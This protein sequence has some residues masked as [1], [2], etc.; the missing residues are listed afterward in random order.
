[1]SFFLL[2]SGILGLAHAGDP[3]LPLLRAVES[4]SSEGVRAQIDKV[5]EDRLVTSLTGLPAAAQRLD[6]NWSAYEQASRSWWPTRR[7]TQGMLKLISGEL[8]EEAVTDW[9]TISPPHYLGP[10]P[11]ERELKVSAVGRHFKV[12]GATLLEVAG[13]YGRG[14][15]V[16]DLGEWVRLNL[17]IKPNA[18]PMFSTSV[19]VNNSEPC[20]YIWG[21]NKEIVLDDAGEWRQGD[22]TGRTV[23]VDLYVSHDC[24]Q[25]QSIPVSIKIDDSHRDGDGELITTWFQVGTKPNIDAMVQL[26]RD[27]PGYSWDTT[28]P[29]K[30][31]S[32]YELSVQANVTGRQKASLLYRLVSDTSL[33]SETRD[34]AP[35]IVSMYS[36]GPMRPEDDLDFSMASRTAVN[37]WI[38]SQNR[39]WT[40]R[41]DPYVPFAVDVIAFDETVTKPPEATDLSRVVQRY[42]DLLSKNFDVENPLELAKL[43]SKVRDFELLV[44]DAQKTPDWESSKEI[45]AL[46]DE[47][48][49]SQVYASSIQRAYSY[50][51]VFML[52]VAPPPT[53]K[54]PP[55]PPPP[56][57][58][59]PPP[60]VQKEKPKPIFNAGPSLYSEQILGSR[61]LLFGAHT[62][63]G[64]RVKFTAD[65]AARQLGDDEKYLVLLTGARVNIV[66]KD[67]FEFGPIMSVGTTRATIEP[68]PEIP[69]SITGE[70]SSFSDGW[71]DTEEEEEE[72]QNGITFGAGVGFD[73]H[74]TQNFGAWLQV[75]G[76]A[77]PNLDET[78]GFS[79]AM[80]LQLRL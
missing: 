43:S 7:M 39:P 45:Q 24:S 20:V 30:P 40:E 41:P 73:F 71:D 55:P 72:T 51:K 29:L 60:V 48:I 27:I 13:T 74:F 26:D 18:T 53:V 5:A 6:S 25:G 42:R 44:R 50:R 64:K 23:A 32:R 35:S 31:E 11:A 22:K 65:V 16:L 80:G 61:I 2:T 67:R 63:V 75:G 47:L 8:A 57:A 77:S 3:A 36:K 14:N 54:P 66:Y 52:P 15:G 9:L 21:A 34:A 38:R 33:F 78:G 56:P 19:W 59:V 17:N 37:T 10:D 68:D 12:D 28:T 79:A 62:A 70:S 76:S 58:Y 1:M 69:D 4:G 49:A 46:A